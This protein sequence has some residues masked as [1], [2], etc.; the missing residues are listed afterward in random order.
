[1]R[2]RNRNPKNPVDELA[3]AYNILVEVMENPRAGYIALIKRVKP[4]SSEPINIIL[5]D[6]QKEIDNEIKSITHKILQEIG[7]EKLPDGIERNGTWQMTI[8]CGI[9]KSFSELCIK[10]KFNIREPLTGSF[11]IH[12]MLYYG[13]WKGQLLWLKDIFLE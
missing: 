10:S 1:M 4:E 13:N 5:L 11:F 7:F 3:E 12:F 6:F 9:K 2:R 8:N